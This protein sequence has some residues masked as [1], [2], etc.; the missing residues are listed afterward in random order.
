MCIHHWEMSVSDNGTVYAKCRRCGEVKGYPSAVVNT[1]R[2]KTV[3]LNKKP[4]PHLRSQC[5]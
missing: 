1:S 2:F 5:K 3:Y 4:A